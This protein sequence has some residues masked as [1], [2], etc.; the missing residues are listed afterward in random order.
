[1]FVVDD[2][3]E[4]LFGPGKAD[5]AAFNLLKA[6]NEAIVTQALG[7]NGETGNQQNMI[8]GKTSP[9]L[10]SFKRF[11]ETLRAECSL[12]WSSIL[13]SVRFLS[14][15]VSRESSMGLLLAEQ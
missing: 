8:G 3:I 6:E 10:E 14:L 9:M 2:M 13:Q 12:G 15:A 7:L 5:L 1:M 4:Q 11:G